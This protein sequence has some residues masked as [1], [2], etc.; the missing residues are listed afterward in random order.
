M[1]AD[2]LKT[3]T[4]TALDELATALDRGH[5]QALVAMLT[6]MSRFHQYSFHNICLIASQRPTA[7]R[8]AGFQAWKSLG[9]FVRRGEKGIA[10]LAPIV[11]RRTD[12]ADDDEERA[13]VG[14]RAAYVFDVA[15]TDGDPLPEINQATG[16][17]GAALARL[18][19]AIQAAGIRVE[20]V[21]DLGGALGTSSGGTI[22]VLQGLAPATEFVIL[23]HEDAHE[24]LHHDD[25]RP[26]SRD[27]REL[28]A[29]AVAFVVAHTLGLDVLD[30]TRDYIHLYHG[31]REALASSLE[32]IQRTAM[33][34]LKAIGA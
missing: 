14:F 27:T 25:D 21:A 12:A 16:D 19:D 17:P 3:L 30:S 2:E 18:R 28:E 11:R 33:T 8:V 6:A 34:I 1:T 4:T 20:Y 10:I 23:A 5:S 13:I 26:Q 24:I 32:R 31:D 29:E 22:Q 7:T 15:Q 9:R